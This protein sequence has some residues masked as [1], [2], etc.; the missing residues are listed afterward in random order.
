[1]ITITGLEETRQAVEALPR[2]VTLALR[3]VAWRTSRT[4]SDLAK[5]NLRRQTHGT[6]KTAD[7]IHVIEEADEQQ[8]VVVVGGNPDRPANLPDWLEFGTRHMAARPYIRPAAD[9]A[10]PAYLREMEQA[11]VSTVQKALG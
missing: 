11:A 8:F 2:A 6:G 10:E 7:S 5:A 9:E 1:M 3:A 4:V